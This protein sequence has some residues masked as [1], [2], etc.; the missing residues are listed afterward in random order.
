MDVEHPF[1]V[2]A[3]GLAG[4]PREERYLSPGVVRRIVARGDANLVLRNVLRMLS[5]DTPAWTMFLQDMRS[6]FPDIK[7]EVGFD[8]DTD[9]HIAA[10]VQ[11]SGAPRLPIDATGT[12]VLQ[13]SQMLAYIA[14]FK[15]RILILDE[16]DSHVKDLRLVSRAWQG[17]PGEGADCAALAEKQLEVGDRKAI[18]EQLAELGLRPAVDE[19]LVTRWRC[20][21]TFAS[22]IELP[23]QSLTGREL[24]DRQPRLVEPTEDLPRAVGRPPPLRA[25]QQ[26]LQGTTDRS[27]P[28]ASSISS[29]SRRQPL[30]TTPLVDGLRFT[31]LNRVRRFAVECNSGARARG[32]PSRARVCMCGRSG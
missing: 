17:Q 24:A 10:Y 19:G 15:P 16:P 23:I 13:A 6:I 9:E 22:G 21:A 7:L 28:W 18:W 5:L 29:L 2:Y 1:T 32:W 31:A 26:R 8:E 14:L 27:R 20:R 25:S 4:I 11:L 3:P 12:S 30:V